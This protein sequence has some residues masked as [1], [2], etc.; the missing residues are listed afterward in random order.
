MDCD[1]IY[2]EELKTNDL[3]HRL[4]MA[5]AAITADE[6]FWECM[7]LG[8]AAAGGTASGGWVIKKIKRTTVTVVRVGSAAAGLIVSFAVYKTCKDTRDDTAQN[9]V[10]AANQAKAHADKVDLNKRDRCRRNTNYERTIRSYRLWK[11]GRYPSGKG[12]RYNPGGRRNAINRAN[13][14]PAKCLALFP[15]GDCG[16]TE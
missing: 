11:G 1:K 5:R 15:S 10:D 13:A 8:G 6:I 9:E 4:N 14:D 2:D 16:T 3:Q 12:Y 7:G